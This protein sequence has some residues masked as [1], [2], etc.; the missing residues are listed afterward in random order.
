MWSRL[1]AFQCPFIFLMVWWYLS[2]SSSSSYSEK[3]F[4]R[5]LE[6]YSSSSFSWWRSGRSMRSVKASSL[7]KKARLCLLGVGRGTWGKRGRTVLRA[8]RAPAAVSYVAEYATCFRPNLSLERQAGGVA[9]GPCG[10]SEGLL[11]VCWPWWYAAR[12]RPA[13]PSRCLRAL[14]GLSSGSFCVPSR[15]WLTWGRISGHGSALVRWCVIPHY[16]R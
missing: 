5:L 8:G 13:D 12:V 16:F 14:W 15:F 6:V 7:W 10:G 1:W 11:V 3:D 2:W 4:L 9:W